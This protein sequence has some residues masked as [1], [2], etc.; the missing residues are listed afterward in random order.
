MYHMHLLDN[1]Q[2]HMTIISQCMYADS[3]MNAQSCVP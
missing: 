3:A 2:P 1:H